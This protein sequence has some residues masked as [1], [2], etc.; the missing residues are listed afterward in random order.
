MSDE[1]LQRLAAWEAVGRS[2]FFGPLSAE[3]GAEIIGS[4]QR[5]EF[6]PGAVIVREADDEHSPS[7]YLIATG[8]AEVWVRKGVRPDRPPKACQV[9]TPG[10]EA[11]TP[12]LQRHTLVARLG[13]GQGFG[14]M[15]L[16]LG[17]PPTATVRAATDLALYTLDAATFKRVLNQHRGLALALEEEIL[18]RSTAGFLGAASPFASLPSD[19]L[20]WLA[21][22]LLP[23]S[24]SADE[25]IVR[26]GEPGDAFYIVRTGQVEMLGRRSDGSLYRL[27]LLGPGEPFG[28]QALL[29]A[30]PHPVT[31]RALSA[32]PDRR[33]ERVE[34]LRL[35]RDAFLETLRQFSERRS[36]FVQLALQRQRPQRI[37]GWEMERQV[38]RGGEVV[39]VLKD[40]QT[41]R[42]LKLSEPAAFLWERMDGERTVR[43]LALAYFARYKAFGLDAVMT[44]MLQLHAAGFVIIQRFDGGGPEAGK[45]RGIGGRSLARLGWLISHSVTHYWS[46][47]DVDRLITLIYRYLLRPLYWRPLLV[48]QSAGIL[49]GAALYV[50]Y[51]A[52]GG[53][54]GVDVRS[55]A[56]VLP[57]ALPL[58][59]VLHEM[60]HAVTAKHF[61]R[62][63]HKAGIGLYLF[64]PV[65]FVDTS[66][67]WMAS[68]GPR[69]ATAF[70][71]PYINFLLS[72]A[73]TLLIPWTPNAALQAA[74]FHFA[75]VGLI[76]GLINLNPLI[77]FDGYY[78][79]MDWLDV[80]N[81]RDKALGFWGAL[82]SGVGRATPDRRLTLI[83]IAYGALAIA[84]TFVV[85]WAVFNGY[86]GYV[87]GP[88]SRFVPAAVA[89]PLG[90]IVAGFMAGLVLRRAWA[91]MQRGARRAQERWNLAS[92]SSNSDS[93]ASDRKWR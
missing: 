63:V 21:L 40:T 86:Q 66:D 1:T 7:Y 25:D 77:E 43:D 23:L 15:S 18:L 54:P 34:V 56:L 83:Y 64:M 59:L 57:W 38:G 46:L 89:L 62:E 14:E 26:E 76:I 90:W 85:A 72:G 69:A 53:L 28:E 9:Y 13:S 75:T 68:R 55:F 17:G 2:P 52:A 12:D 19:A 82:V 79:L 91:P 60:A 67:M 48:L 30:E 4:L 32:P 81:L 73:A 74:L 71:G 49:I 3:A 10:Q 35:S 33:G 88:A 36:Y 70:A 58:H 29:A 78:V 92:D 44:T 37:T 8:E 87:L 41:K 45:G 22:R 24:F 16:L 20:R 93:R 27:S 80:P 61:G 11:W 42:Y 51:L 39:A 31:V 6:P 47:P 50:R 84:Y 65:A 5:R